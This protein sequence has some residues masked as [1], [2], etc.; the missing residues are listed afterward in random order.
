MKKNMFLRVA[1]VL[2]VLTLLSTCAISGT[3]AK[4]V[5]ADT[6]TDTARVAKWGVSIVA[7]NDSMYST[8]YA[9]NTTGYTENT[10]ISSDTV[11]VVAPGTTKTDSVAF[12]ISGDPEVAVKVTALLT[13]NKDVI[14]PA[15]EYDDPTTGDADAAQVVIADPYTPVVYTLTKDGTSVATGTLTNIKTYID[16]LSGNYEANAMDAIVGEYKLTWA[17]EFQNA[18]SELATTNN[19]ADTIL[20]NVA[21]GTATVTGAVTEI[22]YDFSLSI[23]QID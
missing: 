15:G 1:S 20:G 7:W 8:T 23:E 14:L 17:W 2:L 11:S 5:T 12:T 4:Y 16:G 10:V 19:A 9:S 3:F 21:A 22:D 13:V 18:D 6:A